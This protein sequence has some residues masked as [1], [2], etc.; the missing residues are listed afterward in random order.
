MNREEL[1]TRENER[2]KYE[3]VEVKIENTKLKEKLS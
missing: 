3:L 2:M 1:L